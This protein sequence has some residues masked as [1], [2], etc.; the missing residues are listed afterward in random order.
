MI[1]SFAALKPFLFH[2]LVSERVAFISRVAPKLNTK[3][4][5][6]CSCKA[7]SVSSRF[8]SYWEE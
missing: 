3:C 5:I 6:M 1:V 4:V 7:V 8:S 2:L